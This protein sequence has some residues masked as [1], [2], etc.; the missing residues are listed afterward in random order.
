M[1][2]RR[3][4]AAGDTGQAIAR[5]WERRRQAERHGP[6]HRPATGVVAA[7][8]FAVL[9]RPDLAPGG[10]PTALGILGV[11]VAA[12]VVAVVV[13]ARRASLRG[14][15]GNREVPQP[16]GRPWWRHPALFGPA[17]FTAIFVGSVTG[18]YEN[19]PVILGGAI[20]AGVLATLA[21]PRYETADHIH[22]PRL[23]HAPELSAEGMADVAHGDLS[24]DVLKLLVLQHHTGERRV[25]WCADVLGTGVA[26]VR[27]RIARGRRWLELPATEVHSPATAT[28]VRLSA[29]GRETLGYV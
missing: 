7:A 22:G 26:D 18:F 14:P 8:G 20:A 29:E 12:G 13:A 11:M 16:P 2:P 5:V 21:I 28:W 27:D 9:A 23:E 10:L 6:W 1:P 3:D 17:V 24:L 19:V 15:S 25:A 4:V